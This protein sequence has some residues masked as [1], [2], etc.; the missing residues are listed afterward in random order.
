MTTTLD[1]IKGAL[2]NINSY[3]SGEAIAPADAQDCL[4]ALNDMLASWS[5]DHLHVF[6][7]REDILQ[8]VAGQAKYS[9]GNPLCTDLG[10]SPFLGTVTGG[11][12]I[13]TGIASMPL[14]LKLGATLTDLGGV[15]PEGATV[16]GIGA[17]TVTMSDPATATFPGLD[18]VSYT[19]PG[20]FAIPRPLRITGGFT[21]FNSLDFT[22]NVAA[23]QEQYNSVLYK[24]QPGPW[25][26][27][28]WYN[29]TMPYGQLSVYQTPGNNAELHLFSDGLLENLT[30]HQVII[31]P[32]GYVR[33]LKWCLARE[34]WPQYN[35]DR[36]F[37]TLSAQ[38]AA[39]S[40]ALLKSINDKPARE[41]KL[42][43][44]LTGGRRYDKGFIFHGGY[45]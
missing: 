43:P 5:T 37:P 11:S 16:T 24:A 25:P 19:I 33:A 6:G 26:V 35:R 21:R 30:L 34:L 39:E 38:L 45:G 15:I 14:N 20:D 42:D 36:P 41:A 31:M 1:I 40:L 4:D 3:Q 9:V 23:S 27:M 29:N 44:M 7:T 8:W 22:L 28:A 12:N 18:Q 2:R 32:Q 13:I 17:T 10:E